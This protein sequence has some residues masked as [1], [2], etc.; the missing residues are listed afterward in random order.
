[1]QIA[2]VESGLQRVFILDDE[3]L[4]A[5][6]LAIV[7][8]QEGLKAIAFTSPL[9]AIAA[10]RECPPDLLVSDIEMPEMNGVDLALRL[11][12]SHPKNRVILFSGH[13]RLETFLTPNRA[14]IADFEVFTKPVHPRD[15]LRAIRA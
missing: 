10:A 8:E 3:H 2:E 9:D 12:Q 14:S 15:L 4:I 7:L 1:M 5:Q 11:R 6:T 13:T